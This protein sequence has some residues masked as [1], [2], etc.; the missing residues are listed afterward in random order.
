MAQGQGDIMK[1][2]QNPMCHMYDSTD[3]VRGT[4][5][6]KTYQTRKRTNLGYSENFCT[7]NCQTD[8]FNIYGTRAI[9][10]FGRI[11][12]PYKRAVGSPNFWQIRRS[13]RELDSN[14]SWEEINNQAV[15]Q[16]I[17]N[18]RSLGL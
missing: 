1:Y 9:N 18:A 6:N 5:E 13:L 10:H 2:C 4:G 15:Q 11:T 12:E 16:I 7:L 14:A 3:R 17:S 8:W